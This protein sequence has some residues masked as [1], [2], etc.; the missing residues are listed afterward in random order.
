MSMEIIINGAIK[1]LT[2]AGRTLITTKFLCGNYGEKNVISA[3]VHM[4]ETSPH[5]HFAFVPVVTDKKKGHEKG[6][7]KEALCWS[8]KGLNKFHGEFDAH[9]TAVFG[10]D[11]GVI[12]EATKD[13]NKTVQELKRASAI[14]EH[15]RN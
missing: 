3:Y 5:M 12:N 6:S 7:A 13:G 1:K 9:M 8:E 2:R 15:K 4:D 11:I 10:R 14:L